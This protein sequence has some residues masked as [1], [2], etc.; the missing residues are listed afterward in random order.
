MLLRMVT[1]YCQSNVL[2]VFQLSLRPSH[3]DARYLVT[4]GNPLMF[5]RNI[6][7]NLAK[8]TA[9]QH[10]GLSLFW[11]LWN[12]M[13]FRK[14]DL[15]SQRT[16]MASD[17][18]NLDVP[19]NFQGILWFFW[20]ECPPVVLVATWRWFLNKCK[21][22][23]GEWVKEGDNKE[24]NPSIDRFFGVMGSSMTQ[25]STRKTGG[26]DFWGDQKQL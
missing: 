12:S 11:I 20:C 16:Q 7:M 25:Q 21:L 8:Q 24:V 14:N 3:S 15:R 23:E 22:L 10:H 4:D 13:F 1:S 6:P 2:N 26:K 19:W 9:H 18:E 5:K 17:L